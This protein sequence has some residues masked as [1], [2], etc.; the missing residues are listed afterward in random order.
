[1]PK[2]S[3]FHMRTP[4]M[5]GTTQYGPLNAQKM[6]VLPGGGPIQYS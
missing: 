2:G 3:G 6:N 1:M 4:S 5:N